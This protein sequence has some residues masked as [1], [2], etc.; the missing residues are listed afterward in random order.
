MIEENI[1]RVIEEKPLT[2]PLKILKQDKRFIK[3]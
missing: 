1:Q 2:I 3:K